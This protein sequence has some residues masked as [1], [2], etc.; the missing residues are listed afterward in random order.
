MD[1]QYK[2]FVEMI[3]MAYTASGIPVTYPEPVYREEIVPGENGEKLFTFCYFPEAEGIFPVIVQRH[4]YAHLGMDIVNKIAGEEFAKRGFIYVCQHCR[5]TGNSEGEWVPNE[6]ERAD[7]MK[8]VNW[9][10]EQPWCGNVG[11]MGESYLSLVGWVIADVVPDKVKAMYLGNYGADRFTS[12]YKD[13]M[14]RHDIITSWTMENAGVKIDADYLESCRYRPQIEVD[15]KMWGH[16]IE[17]YRDYLRNSDR[18]SPYWAEG[19]WKELSEI[20]SRI[21]VPIYVADQW[22]DHHFGSAV[23]SYEKLSEQSKAHSTFCIGGLNHFGQPCLQDRDVSKA[24]LNGAAEELEW[25]EMTLKKGELPPAR[26]R[27]YL[28]NRDTWREWKS[29]PIPA[30]EVSR[31]QFSA[32]RDGAVYGLSAAP[33]QGEISFIYDP[34]NPVPSHGAE[35]MLH[36][37]EAIGSLLQPEAG[38]R[39]DVISF[40]SEPFE[41]EKEILGKIKV[42]LYVS[43]DAEDTAFTVKV[44]EVMPDGKA[45]NIRST[46]TTIA[47]QKEDYIPGEIVELNFE[48]WEINWMLN[49]GSR[50]RIDISSSD[51]PQYNIH[52][53]FKGPWYEQMETKKAKQHIWCGKDTP[54]VIEIPIHTAK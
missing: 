44:M 2:Q 20:P 42:R 39:D 18:D 35:S 45:Y 1:E 10:A 40:F 46:A 22:Y 8:L 11:I 38:W 33:V 7:G 49:E 43:T 34:E 54:S 36:T 26:V 16:R 25:F 53:N 12:I 14:F 13:G 5:G 41:E 19:M 3:R 27:T 52:S 6:H 17:W 31:L 24:G 48:M 15:E 47:A 29:W 30:D 21:K 9:V 51:F 28:I 4:P 50:L 37:K 32:Q 23:Y